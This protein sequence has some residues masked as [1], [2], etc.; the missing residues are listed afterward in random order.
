[1]SIPTPDPIGLR[2]G[3][4]LRTP[5]YLLTDLRTNEESLSPTRDN[6]SS[7]VTRTRAYGFCKYSGLLVIDCKRSDLCDCFDYPE[8]DEPTDLQRVRDLIDADN[9][10]TS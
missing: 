7:F 10:A 5:T 8:V 9:E 1:M 4:P 3:Y 6:P 2:D